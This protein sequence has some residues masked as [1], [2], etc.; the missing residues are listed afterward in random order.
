[1]ME[2]VSP[3]PNVPPPHGGRPVMVVGAQPR[4]A[5]GAVVMLHGRGATSADILTLVPEL[6]QSDLTFWAPQAAGFT[7]YPQR[8]LAPLAANEP[9]LS[10]ALALVSGLLDE[11]EELGLPAEKTALL[12]FSQGACLALESALRRPRRYAGVIA[13]TGGLIGPPGTVWRAPASLAGT[14]VFIGTSDR[15][16]HVPRERAEESARVLELA[17]AVVDLRIY[18]GLGH[19]VVED[20]LEAARAILSAI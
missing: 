15:D 6:A 1:M 18:P 13:F 20:E 5:R 14:P 11:L 3:V 9:S 8:F 19:T 16:P 7:W 12:G 2:L 10:S 17:G 4:R